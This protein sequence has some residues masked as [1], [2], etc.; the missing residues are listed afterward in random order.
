MVRPVGHRAP[1]RRA[2]PPDPAVEHEP[3]R[4]AR[5]ETLSGTVTPSNAFIFVN[6]TTN[7]DSPLDPY[8]AGWVPVPP[9]GVLDVQVPIENYRASSSSATM[10]RGR[11]HTEP[12]ERLQVWN[13]TV[14]L[15]CTIRRGDIYTPLIAW[16]NAQFL[17]SPRA[18]TGAPPTLP[19]AN[20]EYGSLS[21]SSRS[22]MGSTSSLAG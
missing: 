18:V 6:A 13:L 17:R 4:L 8:W 9:S 3:H 21:P 7:L 12:L 22:S 5:Y 14:A 20:D 15:T 16:D 2:N 1:R 10:S 11:F 19:I